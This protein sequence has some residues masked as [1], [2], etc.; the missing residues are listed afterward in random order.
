MVSTGEKLYLEDIAVGMEFRSAEHQLDAAQ[1]K[2]FASQFDPQP[3]HLDEEAA[4][5][6]FF[7]GLAAS[8]WHTMA[9]TMRLLVES[10]PFACGVIG[11]GAEVSWPR[12]TRPSDVLHV[13]ST[14][15]EIKPSR[16][17]QDR[18]IVLMH[19]LTLNRNGDVCQ[20]VT[21]KLLVFR[22]EAS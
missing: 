10:L 2:A 19:S 21:A 6:S 5:A 13:K 22:K 3:F 8:G 18:G 17:K 20:D 1:I 11:G 12:P 9:I 16:S 4:R 15:V 14:V 7:Q